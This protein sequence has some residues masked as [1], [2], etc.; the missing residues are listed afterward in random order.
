[1]FWK[2]SLD[3][4]RQQHIGHRYCPAG[5]DSAEKEQTRPTNHSQQ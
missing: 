5:N 2:I 1:M 3:Q 4:R